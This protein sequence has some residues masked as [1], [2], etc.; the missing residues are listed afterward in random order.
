MLLER[1]RVPAEFSARTF[2][3][4]SK[5]LKLKF[6]DLEISESSPPAGPSVD[7]G[8]SILARLMPGHFFSK[9]HAGFQL[10][11]A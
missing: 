3:N 4:R 9:K 7:I 5:V 1:S 10:I 2:F 6:I 11:R 8:A